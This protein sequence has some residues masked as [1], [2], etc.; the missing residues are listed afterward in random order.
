ME[1]NLDGGFLF[2][3][4]GRF[5]F[6]AHWLICPSLESAGLQLSC[7][8]CIN[9]EPLHMVTLVCVPSVHSQQIDLSKYLL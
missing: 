1:V 6:V 3:L 8:L 2:S 7:S 4:D 5:P 9:Q